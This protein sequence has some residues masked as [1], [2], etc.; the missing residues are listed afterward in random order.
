LDW[1]AGLWLFTT[2]GTF[3]RD[4]DAVQ[5][6]KEEQVKRII[7]GAFPI[8]RQPDLSSSNLAERSPKDN[9][10]RRDEARRIAANIAKLPE[11]LRQKWKKG[12][13]TSWGCEIRELHPLTAYTGLPN[14][15]RLPSR[16]ERRYVILLIIVQAKTHELSEGE[17]RL[18]NILYPR[19]CREAAIP[20]GSTAI[21]H[22]YAP[23]R[24]K[25]RFN[26]DSAGKLG[27]LL[28]IRVAR[29]PAYP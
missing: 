6:L 13:V 27:N 17:W 14:E 15:P 25:H 28:P 10:S 1:A 29:K 3:S 23:S 12:K 16:I 7:A 20:K 4:T 2:R 19:T 26:R 5:V 18:G 8:W 21:D 24:A 9:R 11:L 22:D